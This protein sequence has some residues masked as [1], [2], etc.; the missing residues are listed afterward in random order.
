MHAR[1]DFEGN[2]S[3][4]ESTHKWFSSRKQ[5][6]VKYGW[7]FCVNG[8]HCKDHTF[9][10]LG[11]FSKSELLGIIVNHSLFLPQMLLSLCTSELET[12]Q[13]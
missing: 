1:S 10:I 6:Y 8:R 9:L 5:E 11:H 12:Q 13:K 7:V 4:K 3:H 2:G